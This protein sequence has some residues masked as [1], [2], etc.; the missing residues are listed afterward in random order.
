MNETLG[1][2]LESRRPQAKR[3]IQ[4]LPLRRSRH[5]GPDMEEEF[6]S[7]IERDDV[8][9]IMDDE[10]YTVSWELTYVQRYIQSY[11][12]CIYVCLRHMRLGES[13]SQ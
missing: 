4:L 11:R 10:A 7:E 12:Y 13:C 3:L 2:S 8:S 6:A 9:H 5:S 1:F